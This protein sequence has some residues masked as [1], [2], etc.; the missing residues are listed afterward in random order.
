MSFICTSLQLLR[1]VFRFCFHDPKK[2]VFIYTQKYDSETTSVSFKSFLNCRVFF[3]DAK[4]YKSTIRMK[5]TFIIKATWL[6]LILN[7][8]NC[9]AVL[10]ENLSQNALYSQRRIKNIKR[11]SN[12]FSF[13][14]NIFLQLR[15]N[16]SPLAEAHTLIL[17]SS[18]LFEIA[19]ISFPREHYSF[20]YNFTDPSHTY[21]DLTRMKRS[22]LV[23]PFAFLPLCYLWICWRNINDC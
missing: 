8:V 14:S 16:I 1:F 5:R 13:A 2:L 7:P 22:S 3:S 9:S 17:L 6:I 10:K 4:I 23:K 11:I 18:S 20:L 21:V 15:R 19:I 12:F